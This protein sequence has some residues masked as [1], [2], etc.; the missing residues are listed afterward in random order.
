[1]SDEFTTVVDESALLDGTHKTI[2]RAVVED[3]EGRRGIA[4]LSVKL[5]NGRPK[6]FLTVKKN[7]D[8][9]SIQT[10]TADWLL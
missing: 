3:V 4:F 5:Q 10:A 7:H 8:K 2:I 9:E 1:M 6:F